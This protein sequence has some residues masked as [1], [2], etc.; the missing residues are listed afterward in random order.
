MLTPSIL[1]SYHLIV[2][3]V[4][5]LSLVVLRLGLLV[6]SMC[7]LGGVLGQRLEDLLWHWGRSGQMVSLG[8]ESVLISGVVNGDLLSV[9]SDVRVVSLGHLRLV[10]LVSGVL[11][12]SLLVGGDSVGGLVVES[13]GSVLSALIVG[14]GDDGVLVSRLLLVVVLGLV[15]LVLVSTDGGGSHDSQEGAGHDDLVVGWRGE[16]DLCFKD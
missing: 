14:L 12:V 16:L 1:S 13:V 15:L 3:V 5:G 9:L 8:T 7:L 6:V 2:L 10:L 11:G 4:L